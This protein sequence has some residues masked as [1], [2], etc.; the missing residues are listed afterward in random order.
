[1]FIINI[2]L[3]KNN[4]K[5]IKILRG[6]FLKDKVVVLRQIVDEVKDIW[7][8]FL[9]KMKK[10]NFLQKLI[11]I[12]LGLFLIGGLI[13]KTDSVFDIIVVLIYTVVVFIVL[14]VLKNIFKDIKVKII[15]V[16]CLS[17]IIVY[18]YTKGTSRRMLISVTVYLLLIYLGIKIFSLIKP[19]QEFKG[20]IAF[21]VLANILGIVSIIFLMNIFNVPF[22]GLSKPE[23]YARKYF[24]KNKIERKNI[25]IVRSRE[26]YGEEGIDVIVDIG[27]LKLLKD[28]KV[29]DSSGKKLPNILTE[30]VLWYNNSKINE[31]TKL[32]KVPE[33]EEKYIK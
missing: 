29:T 16:D 22:K 32:E 31:V 23:H 21:R 12:G 10:Q 13:L 4:T 14:N 25:H 18:L 5:H 3:R 15:F 20:K 8:N 7:K 19:V 2:F 28:K 6:D 27:D 1:M 9:L 33:L 17:W 26:S 24:I 11:I 30:Y